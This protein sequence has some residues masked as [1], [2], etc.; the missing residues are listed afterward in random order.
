MAHLS[1]CQLGRLD[2]FF[3]RNTGVGFKMD[4]FT[5]ACLHRV[6]DHAHDFNVDPRGSPPKVSAQKGATSYESARVYYPFVTH[7][8]G[9]KCKSYPQ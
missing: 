2:M 8:Y 1:K 6:K 5:A 7:G 9:S 4:G 3:F